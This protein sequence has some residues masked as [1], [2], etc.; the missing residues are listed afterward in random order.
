MKC[1]YIYI[2]VFIKCGR[3]QECRY[4]RGLMRAAGAFQLQR[5]SN[6]NAGPFPP[7]NSGGL[8]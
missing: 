4:Q 7:L 1:I 2:L 3:K 5:L 6:A 8:T